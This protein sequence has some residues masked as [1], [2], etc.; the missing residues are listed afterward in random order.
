MW[1]CPLGFVITF[2]I[3]L[4]VSWITNLVGKEDKEMKNPDLF[5]PVIGNRMRRSR[6]QNSVSAYELSRKYI[7]EVESNVSE[8]SSTKL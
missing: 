6:R 2:V 7:F 4:L 5:F 3:G 1:Y 8:K